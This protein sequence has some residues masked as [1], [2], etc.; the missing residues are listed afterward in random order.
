MTKAYPKKRNE[1]HY[2]GGTHRKAANACLF[3]NTYLTEWQ[4]SFLHNVVNWE[5]PL[6]VAQ[7]RSL[8]MI[9]DK[10]GVKWA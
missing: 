7:R 9:C 2:T 8:K 3:T 1:Y 6:S 4:M 10:C 5:G